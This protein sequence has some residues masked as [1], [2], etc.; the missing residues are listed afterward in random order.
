M[1]WLGFRRAFCRSHRLSFTL[2]SQSVCLCMQFGVFVDFSAMTY[3][4]ANFN[5]VPHSKLC[6]MTSTHSMTYLLLFRLANVALRDLATISTMLELLFV[7]LFL[8]RR[9][10]FLRRLSICSAVHMWFIHSLTHISK[11]HNYTVSVLWY[12]TKIKWSIWS[13]DRRSRV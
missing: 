5:F 8:W 6:A 12:N 9:V 10:C 7:R 3:L 1:F 2:G 11:L 13:S 4:S